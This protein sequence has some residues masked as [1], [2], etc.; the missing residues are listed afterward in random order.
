MTLQLRGLALSAADLQSLTDWP[1]ALIEDYLNILNSLE[2]ITSVVDPIAALNPNQLVGT[3]SS[4]NLVS[5]GLS[6]FVAGT[7][8]QVNVASTATGG[9]VLSTPQ[10]IHALAVPA[11]A[12]VKFPVTF[13][14]GDYTLLAT[15]TILQ[16]NLD[17]ESGTV[18]T[19]VASDPDDGSGVQ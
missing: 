2:D 7:L 5:V 8:N 4:S 14:N 17:F 9:V 16:T 12:G 10:D 6:S 3:D 1:D 13:V 18:T 15:D 11:F 19:N